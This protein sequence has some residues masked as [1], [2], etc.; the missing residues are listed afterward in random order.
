MRRKDGREKRNEG[1]GSGEDMTVN[2]KN[3]EVQR[4]SLMKM[5]TF[6]RFY[7]M[8]RYSYYCQ[9]SAMYRCIVHVWVYVSFRYV[10]ACVY[11]ARACVSVNMRV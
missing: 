1:E 6:F 10:L 4:S 8:F 7:L 5:P 9:Y 11:Y 2:E 3:N